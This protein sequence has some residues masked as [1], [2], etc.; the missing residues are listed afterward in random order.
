MLFANKKA[1]NMVPMVDHD[2]VGTLILGYYRNGTHFLKDVIVD[3]HPL[4]QQFDEIC[5]NNTIAE[6]ETLTEIPGY[7]VCIL[8]N[9]IPK[10]FLVGR[11]DLLEK[12]HVINLTR[13][14]KIHHF[15]S[16]WFWEQNTMQERLQDS[17]QFRH[18]G[19]D[20]RSYKNLLAQGQYTYNTNSIVAW[21]QEQLINHHLPGNVTVDYS[22]LPNYA[23]D[24]IQWQPNKYNTITLKDLF[25]NHEEIQHLLGNFTI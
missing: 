21:L 7:K 11:K 10:F 14:D 24:N 18:H 3:Q 12:W 23:T 19:T 5:N 25:S 2:K 9:A 16:Y 6:L 8:N 22:E 13:N 15:I 1:G 17:G 4:I 20:H